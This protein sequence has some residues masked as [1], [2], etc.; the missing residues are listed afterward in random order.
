VQRYYFKSVKK[1]VYLKKKR[2]LPAENGDE[3]EK[4][5][6]ETLCPRKP[7]DVD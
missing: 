6:D 3:K 5:A 2:T 7:I 4:G 1:A